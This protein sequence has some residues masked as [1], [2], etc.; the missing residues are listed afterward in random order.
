M[1][2]FTVVPQDGKLSFLR[3]KVVLIYFKHETIDKVQKVNDD[4]YKTLSEKNT[5]CFLCFDTNIKG[6]SGWRKHTS[7]YWN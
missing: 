6:G 3:N 7:I 5:K 1:C 4:K 2:S